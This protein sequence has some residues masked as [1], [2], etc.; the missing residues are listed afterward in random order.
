MR[1][2]RSLTALITVSLFALFTVQFAFSDELTAMIQDDLLKLGYEPGDTSGEPSIQ[3]AVAIS[4]FQ[5]ENGIEVTGEV[6]P[7]LAGIL[8]AKVDGLETVPTGTLAPEA[9]P[10]AVL[11][12]VDTEALRVAKESCIREKIAEAEERNKKRRGF[13]SLLSAVSRT[14]GQVGSDDV[15]VATG[16]VAN[17]AAT[18]AD[19]SSAA[20]DLG[21]TD[22]ELAE[23]ENLQ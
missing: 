9:E 19:L 20:R 12:A 11:P 2:H 18:A 15:A 10:A 5:A 21:V 1:I 14:A 16:T 4:K 23:C 6:S 22:D 7:Q 13:G 17:T 8:S 3:T